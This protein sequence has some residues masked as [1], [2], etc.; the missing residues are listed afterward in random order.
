MAVEY[1][2]KTLFAWFNGSELQVLL[3][4]NKALPQSLTGQLWYII[5]SV[6]I[7]LICRN[8][9]ISPL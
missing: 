1:H 7:G 3:D 4:L 6:Y 2:G 5:R 8:A 9:K